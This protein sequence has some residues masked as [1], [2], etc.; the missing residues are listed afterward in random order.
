[1]NRLAIKNSKAFTLMEVL[2]SILIFSVVIIV[3]YSSLRAFFVSSEVITENINQSDTTRNLYRRFSLDLEALYV[4]QPPEYKKTEFNSEPDA[5][6]FVGTQETLGDK[7]ASTLSFVS[8]AHVGSGYEETTNAARIVYYLR[9]TESNSFDLCRADNL[10]PEKEDLISCTDPVLCKNVIVFEILYVDHQGDEHTQWDSDSK[11]NE[12][13]LPSI[14][15]FI[16]KF[17]DEQSP[18]I[19]QTSFAVLTERGPLD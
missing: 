4:V 11:E 8:L 5:F 17:G 2:I 3:L 12:F 15:K 14:I 16:I 9:E 18:Q 13:A 10:L 7:S 6:R 19:F 1:M